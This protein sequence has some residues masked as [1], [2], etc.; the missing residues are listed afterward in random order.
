[1]LSDFPNIS[2]YIG[3][4]IAA[5]IG[6][7]TS[8][9]EKIYRKLLSLGREKVV[10]GSI[11]VLILGASLFI[12]SSTFESW[13]QTNELIFSEPENFI[14]SWESN[15]VFI[16]FIVA[17]GY[18]LVSLAPVATFLSVKTI[19]GLSDKDKTNH[20]LPYK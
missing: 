13:Y 6:I 12:S 20:D 9:S 5:L 1:M 3:W 19:K 17:M 4:G 2:D 15:P 18:L 8:F 10:D 7:L 11:V 16:T 14:S